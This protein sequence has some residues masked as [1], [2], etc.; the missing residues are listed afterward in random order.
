MV[1]GVSIVAQTTPVTWPYGPVHGHPEVVGVDD[2]QTA[3]VA[4]LVAKLN[5][6]RARNAGLFGRYRAAGVVRR[7]SPVVPEAYRSM[8]TVLDW[9]R[10]A[11]D[12]L[13]ERVVLDAVTGDAAAVALFGA[14]HLST[15]LDMG[16]ID[17]LVTGVGFID[18]GTGDP[19]VGEPE[20]LLTFESPESLT[21]E[22]SARQR[23]VT[24]AWRQV[25]EQ[26]PNGPWVSLAELKEPD[27]TTTWWFDEA[28]DTIDMKVD[29]HRL[30]VVTTVPLVNRSTTRSRLGASEITA[31]LQAITDS[32]VKSLGLWDVAEEFY[33]VVKEWVL[34]ATKDQFRRA[35]GT[36][37]SDW[38][39]VYGRIRMMPRD[40]MTGELPAVVT[41][42]SSSP[43]PFNVR[44][45]AL[46]LQAAA[47]TGL[48]E[49][50]FGV[51]SD[52]PTSADAMM[53]AEAR[54]NRRAERRQGPLGQA[55]V[56]AAR[57][58]LLVA[59]GRPLD[60]PLEVGLVWRDPA[61]PTRAAM[62][63][64]VSKLV[65]AGVVD[66]RSEVAREMAGMTAA[67]RAR[68][69]AEVDALPPT[70]PSAG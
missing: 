28:G 5:H 54:V 19:V 30:G 53:R 50:Y 21:V 8:V 29:P 14:N 44:L 12:A 69:S 63:D 62:A 25:T 52:N 2:D 43:E 68:Y 3:L 39:H 32:A 20:T 42:P 49:D 18:I 9:Q 31:S 10:I 37:M 1:A 7:S 36:I 70:Q 51:T 61:T 47:T 13:A 16:V 48:P 38:E 67:Q 65:G 22:W 23:R 64:S 55:L 46:A 4:R 60:R 59:E 58:G 17:Q 11:V 24:A 56:A 27:R 15:E 41:T 34:G 35:D 33:S 66:A 26:G 6:M 57:L 40:A 45:R